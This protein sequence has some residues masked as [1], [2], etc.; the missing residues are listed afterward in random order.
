MLAVQALGYMV[1]VKR[2]SLDFQ[3][4]RRNWLRVMIAYAIWWCAV[5]VVAAQISFVF[6][7][8]LTAFT[9]LFIGGMVLAFVRLRR[10]RSSS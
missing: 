3:F 10:I 8:A 4:W 2:L 1:F 9:C 7:A 6:G 5:D